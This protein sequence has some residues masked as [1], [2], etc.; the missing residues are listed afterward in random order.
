MFGLHRKMRNY[1]SEDKPHFFDEAKKLLI[2]YHITIG[3]STRH[4]KT[5]G[6]V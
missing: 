2:Q 5:E 6:S 3:E 4:L 1:I